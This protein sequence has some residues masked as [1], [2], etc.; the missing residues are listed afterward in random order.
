MR[1][2]PD[3]GVPGRFLR[4]ICGLIF[5]RG[6]FIEDFHFRGFGVLLYK[7]IWFDVGKPGCV[8]FFECFTSQTS[9]TLSRRQSFR[10]G[11]RLTIRVACPS[12]LLQLRDFVSCIRLSLFAHPSPS[13]VARP[14]VVLRFHP[15]S[16]RLS[17]FTTT[18][19]HHL[20]T[21]ILYT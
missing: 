21:H 3:S 16:L 7:G 11:S 13:P 17:G 18:N 8:Q 5:V 4:D 1:K 14:S 15:S 6:I 20:Q 9:G 2:C 10:H 12:C 19:F